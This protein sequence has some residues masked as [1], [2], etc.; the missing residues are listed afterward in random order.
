MLK[1]YIHITASESLDGV[2]LD[3]A[4]KKSDWIVM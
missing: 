2:E 4:V 3:I 1:Y